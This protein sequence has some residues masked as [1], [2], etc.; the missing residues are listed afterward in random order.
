MTKNEFKEFAKQQGCNC[1]YSG[2]EKKMYVYG[3]NAD[4]VI[5]HCSLSVD[6]TLESTSIKV[7]K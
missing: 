6:F 3:E 4:V 5:L 1:R 2:K 7:K